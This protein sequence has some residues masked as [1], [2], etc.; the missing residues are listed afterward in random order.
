MNGLPPEQHSRE[1]YFFDM[2][3]R[4]WLVEL[5]MPYANPCLVGVPTVA[6]ELEDIRLLDIDDRFADLEGFVK[7]DLYR[8]EPLAEKFDLIVC[9]PPFHTVSFSQLF[10]ALR[11]LANGDFRQPVLITGL[12]RREQDLLATF[13]PF[14]LRPTGVQAR[15]VSVQDQDGYRQILWY[16]NFRLPTGTSAGRVPESE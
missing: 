1:Q 12:A 4:D 16:S 15:Y 5:L 9:D 10:N 2:P 8:P 14:A 6:R 3:T 7:W 11:V 13:Y